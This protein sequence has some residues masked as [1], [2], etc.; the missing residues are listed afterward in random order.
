MELSISNRTRSSSRQDFPDPEADGGELNYVFSIPI[1]S[2]AKLDEVRCHRLCAET[3]FVLLLKFGA[4][5]SIILSGL[6]T[7]DSDAD[8]EL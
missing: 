1:A 4:V 5:L 6:G 8:K 2:L 3:P 7:R